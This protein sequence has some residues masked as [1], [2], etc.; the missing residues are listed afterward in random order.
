MSR[1]HLFNYMGVLIAAFMFVA[2]GGESGTSNS[3]GSGKSSL[4]GKA[5]SQTASYTC[6]EEIT[7]LCRF[8]NG[9][10]FWEA[11]TDCTS[12]GTSSTCKCTV[13]QGLGTCSTD[14]TIGGACT[15]TP[16]N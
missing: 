7:H 9:A 10:K 11:K 3:G 6:A 16:V 2:C 14:G 13:I 15:G 8:Q 12:G 4:D 1:L 5:C